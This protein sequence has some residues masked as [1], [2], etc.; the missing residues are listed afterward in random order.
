[1]HLFKNFTLYCLILFMSA[2]I[3][4]VS[5]QN[6]SEITEGREYWLGVPHIKLLQAEAIRGD[7][8]VAL[9]I[10]SK[11]NTQATI[12][13]IQAGLNKTVNIQANKITQV[14]I[15]DGYM[16]RDVEVVKDLGLHVQSKDPISVAVYM[17]YR[18]SGEA[19]RVIPVEWLGKKYFSTNLYQ[20]ETDEIK[21]GQIIVIA[22]ADNTV[23]KYRPTFNTVKVNAGNL[24]SV[25]MQKGETFLIEGRPTAGMT[26]DDR[27]DLTGTYIEGS[28]PIAVLSGH[29]KGAF[30]RYYIGSRAGWMEPFANF[31]RNTLIE[32]MWPVELWGKEYIS[33]PLK[34]IDRPRGLT[35]VQ[36]DAGD[37]IRFVAGYDSTMLY[38][39]RQDGSGLMK[40][41]PTLKRGEWYQLTNMENPAYY[42]SNKPF[43]AAQYGKTW[44]N[45]NGMMGPIAKKKDVDEPQNPHKNGQGMLIVLAPIDHWCSYASFRS[46]SDMDN[47]I[48]ITFREKDR[49]K[50]KFDGTL[51]STKWGSTIKPINGTEYAYIT[52]NI[53]PGDHW[54]EA[55]DSA[56]FA[57]YAYGNWDRTKDGFAYGYPVGINYTIP[58]KDSLYILDKMDCGNVDG[59]AYSVPDTA[60]CAGL[61][62]VMFN[63]D[64]SYNY[65]WE[66]DE[67]FSNGDKTA[68]FSLKIIDVRKPARGYVT[69][70]TRSGNTIVKIYEY[71][72][73]EITATPTYINFG[74]LKIG[75]KVCKTFQLK[76]EG[77]VPTT[78]S[79]LWLQ[80]NL[81]EFEITTKDLPVTLQP[82]EFKDIEVCATAITLSNGS[83]K[84][85]VWA[86]LSCYSRSVVGLEFTTGE[87]VV[88]ISD[89]S[90]KN[91]PVGNEEARTVKIS[92][93]SNTTVELYSIDWADK[94]HF[95]RVEGLPFPNTLSIAPNK[96]FDFTV[97]YK[98]DKPG[99]QDSTRA[100]FVGNTV[101]DKLYSDWVGIGIDPGPGITGYDW[102]KRRVIDA[103]AGVT[104]YPHYITIRND[105]NVKIPVRDVV[106]E[107]D[108]D[109]V[110]RIDRTQIPAELDSGESKQIAAFF[111]PKA[112]KIYNSTVKMVS[113]F[114]G[115]D[116][117]VSDDLKGIGIQ[118]HI[119]LT[120]ID[121]GAPIL[122]GASKDSFSVVSHVTVAQPMLLTIFKMYIDGPDKTAF[123][124][125]PAFLANANNW[126]T[127]QIGGQVQVPIKFTAMH[128]GDHT[129]QLMVDSDAPEKPVGE[130][131]GRGYLQGLYSNDAD[132]GLLFVTQQ[133]TRTVF[134]TNTGSIPATINRDID[135]SLSTVTGDPGTYRVNKWWTAKSK[136]QSPAAPFDLNAGDTLYVEV[137]FN[138]MT[139][140][141]IVKD[142]PNETRNYKGKI[143]Y[144]TS[145]GTSV[146]NVN[147]NATVMQIIA[148]IPSGTYVSNPGNNIEISY[149]LLKHPKEPKALSAGQY[150]DVTAEITFKSPGREN[151]QDI[152]PSQRN[153]SDGT[154]FACKDIIREGTITESWAC[155]KADV[156]NGTTA[157]VHLNGST[158]LNL[159]GNE[160]TLFK[161]KFKTFL[162]DLDLI[163][164]P[165]TFKVDDD[166][167]GYTIIEVVPGDIKINPVCVNT[168][169]L[170]KLTGTK[171][172]LAQ[173]SPNPAGD[174]TT[175]NYAVGLEAQTSITLY[176]NSGEKVA[177]LL[178]QVLAP[179][180]YEL[181]IDIQAL[182]LPSGVYHYK[183]ESGPFT[184]TKSMVI[185]K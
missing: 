88:T 97:Y 58:C 15:T 146:S 87:P 141:N 42:V 56:N 112:E 127:I 162:S 109:G 60:E 154:P 45:E 13:D 72:P 6:K 92:N 10:S 142:D 11:V 106:I 48:Y 93:I 178:D 166:K 84:D 151:V 160:S 54:V 116:I 133:N 168:L 107:N 123:V 35:I 39:M 49:F 139:D 118:P 122:V 43:L 55:I 132:H 174:F 77:T 53:P 83:Y 4:L 99:V 117:Y 33:A 157:T 78:V 136:L 12:T 110:F 61:F 158:A 128:A 171:Y 159:A 17:S 155:I 147:G 16:S 3:P 182:G 124:I 111:A 26:Q 181:R 68:T 27:T 125:D 14:E 91:I 153:L 18:W 161:M 76:N 51:I 25:T 29:T 31:S 184:D 134:L 65:N 94:T 148:K 28:K 74:M 67:K 149:L 64:S 23:V 69:A 145:I 2:V 62:T 176:N 20:D 50:L 152:Y 170:I 126:S 113:F 138:P 156:V 173:N 167:M 75:E 103:Y 36:D 177:T 82:G 108:P 52:E 115:K 100:L 119:A 63:S 163:P 175:I 144:Q 89:A 185:T 8:P 32:M 34:Y 95:T 137:L 183:I 164:L 121:Y 5:Q 179:A 1:M 80:K 150:T 104:E 169:R 85:S 143:D 40:I 114:N 38:Q 44:W 66:L 96:D 46:P 70:L 102:L 131:I 129:A 86:Q 98:P 59:K 81:P 30:P 135:K 21:P 9:W 172:A 7:F 73:E 37:L 101:K 41:G 57:A 165:I 24:A 105:G 79:K 140:K 47:F 19:Y 120:G 22:T 90:W 180:D 130:L 71:T